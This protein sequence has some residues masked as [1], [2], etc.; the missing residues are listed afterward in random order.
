MA[1]DMTNTMLDEWEQFEGQEVEV[2]DAFAVG[3]GTQFIQPTF[4][5]GSVNIVQ[6]EAR[7]GRMKAV[8]EAQGWLYE[9][10]KVTPQFLEVFERLEQEGR[11]SR[12][13]LE[14]KDKQSGSKRY[15]EYLRIH[16]SHFALLCHAVIHPSTA[17]RDTAKQLGIAGGVWVNYKDG[18][19]TYDADTVVEVLAVHIPLFEA[20]FVDER[21]TPVPVLLRGRGYAAKELFTA[22]LGHGKIVQ[23]ARTAMKMTGVQMW[24]FVAPLHAGE[25]KI[26]HFSNEKQEGFDV[27]PVLGHEEQPSEA[28]VTSIAVRS[29]LSKAIRRLVLSLVPN[30]KGGV[31]AIPGGPVIEWCQQEYQRFAE[32]AQEYNP[33]GKLPL[34]KKRQATA[35][36]LNRRQLADASLYA[37]GAAAALPASSGDDDMA[38]RDAIY[39]RLEGLRDWFAKNDEPIL[40]KECQEHLDSF[41]APDFHLPS[42]RAFIQTT[43][44]PEK[45]K[46][47]KARAK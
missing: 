32:N 38:E 44:G 34:G 24:D 30:A 19:Q 14:H 43:A 33:D 1:V 13:T 31:V 47:L 9:S 7:T 5:K 17:S 41:D 46:R 11:A 3:G 16:D 2:Q 4:F 22:L 6:Q 45:A 29:D 18:S 21:G 25:E 28:Y 37:G 40:A 42:I 36:M 8:G 10:D 35:R 20:G 15:V 12:V 23:W 39:S 26:Q 27:Y